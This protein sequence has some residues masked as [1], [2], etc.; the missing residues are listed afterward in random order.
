MKPKLCDDSIILEGKEYTVDNI[1]STGVQELC[2]E[3][4]FIPSHNGITPLF[5]KHSPLSNHFP[6]QFQCDG[7]LFHS[8]EQHFM[9]QKTVFFKDT[10]SACQILETKSLVEAR[11]IGK[12]IANYDSKIVCIRLCIQSL[13]KIN[14]VQNS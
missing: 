2:P 3:H 12:K 1:L 10:E 14:T 11:N 13:A 7:Q 6:V 5:T 9:Y 4:I 8:S